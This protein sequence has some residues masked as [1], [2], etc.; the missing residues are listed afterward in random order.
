MERGEDDNKEI[1]E[2]LEKRLAL[3][4]DRYGHGVR[5]DDDTREWGTEENSWELM[6]LEEALDGMIYSAAS[7]IRILRKRKECV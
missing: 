6:M 5:V 2:L 3:G 4:K 7:M 1:M